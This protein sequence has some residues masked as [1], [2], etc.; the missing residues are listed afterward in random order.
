MCIADK[1]EAE[2]IG[3]GRSK[4]QT[5]DEEG[6]VGNGKR[7]PNKTAE[8]ALQLGVPAL[9]MPAILLGS[10]LPYLLPAL[11]MAT[12]LS[13]LINKGALITAALYATKHNF[14]DHDKLIYS[15]SPS[16]HRDLSNM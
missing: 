7:K 8:Y 11:K 14:I 2:S 13:L 16:Y 5:K 10:V 6:P 12:I 15:P 3:M 1:P 9:M 4:K